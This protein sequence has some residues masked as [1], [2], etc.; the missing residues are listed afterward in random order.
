LSAFSRA[1]QGVP[2]YEAAARK[3]RGY[4]ENRLIK[5]GRLAKTRAGKRL[6]PDAELDDYAYVVAGLDDYTRVYRDPSAGKLAKGLAQQAWSRF[7]SA[8][9]WQREAIPLLATLRRLPALPDGALP[10][11]AS[12]L[13][14]ATQSLLRT[15][16]DAALSAVLDQALALALPAMQRNPFDYPGGLEGLAGIKPRLNREGESS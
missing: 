1:G 3:L 4:L 9:G 7:F 5:Q 8:V 12:R 10:S 16:P 14:A 13:I 6:F 11:A 15:Q 2:R